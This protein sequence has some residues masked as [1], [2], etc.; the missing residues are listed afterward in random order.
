VFVLAT[1]FNRATLLARD[2]TFITT[3]GTVPVI[4]AITALLSA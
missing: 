1:R 4:L 2:A 3:I